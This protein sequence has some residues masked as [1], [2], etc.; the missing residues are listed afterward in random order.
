MS[1]FS[2]D[3]S[4]VTPGMLKHN[5]IWTVVNLIV[6]INDYPGWDDVLEV[7]TWIR[8][9]GSL[10]IGV[11]KFWTIRNLVNGK[12]HARARSFCTMLNEKTRQTSRIPDE[13]RHEI[14]PIV[15]KKKEVDEL[16]LSTKIDEL[17]DA[18]YIT[19]FKPERKDIGINKYVKNVKYANWIVEA[20]PEQILRDYQLSTI[21]LAYKRECRKSETIQSLCEPDKDNGI[22]EKYKSIDNLFGFTHLLQIEGDERFEEIV[23]GRTTWKRRDI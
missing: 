14:S 18:K 7:D 10:E 21:T 16:K 11:F 12:F 17:V 20:I 3:E 13:V 22:L 1:G 2:S 9:A 4:G 6:E 19:S 8:P 15:S 23:R 5:L